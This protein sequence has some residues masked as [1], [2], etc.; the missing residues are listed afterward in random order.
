MDI[1]K[2]DFFKYFLTFGSIW[3]RLQIVRD[4]YKTIKN[5]KHMTEFTTKTI[6]IGR[7]PPENKPIEFIKFLGKKHGIF[8]NNIDSKPSDFDYIELIAKEYCR[9]DGEM[10]DL[11]YAYCVQECRDD[12]VLFLGKW[13]SGNVY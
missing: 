9:I 1:V 11:M 6:V 4:K 3:G 13:N 10:C 8:T 5:K 2:A 12:G 7:P